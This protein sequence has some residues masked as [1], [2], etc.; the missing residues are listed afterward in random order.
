MGTDWREKWATDPHT[1]GCWWQED[2]RAQ[3]LLRS[4]R[5]RMRL[6]EIRCLV[7]PVKEDVLIE[8]MKRALYD[9]NYARWFHMKY[10]EAGED[11]LRA[12]DREARAALAVVR[13]S[14]GG[15]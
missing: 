14:E 1:G 15:W 7:Q 9:A 5:E 6:G 4:F 2:D 12:L 10:E 11:T 13:R 3:G 8:Q